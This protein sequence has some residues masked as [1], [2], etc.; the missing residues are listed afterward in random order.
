MVRLT[1]QEMI[2]TGKIVCGA[3][4][5]GRGSSLQHGPH[6]EIQGSARRQRERSK[7]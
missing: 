4:L 7:L 2:T 5:S 6:G 3:Q 1:D